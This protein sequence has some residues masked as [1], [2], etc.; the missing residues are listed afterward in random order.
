MKESHKLA[1]IDTGVHRSQS[2][3]RQPLRS[4]EGPI[5]RQYQRA[6]Q[7]DT[8]WVRP[9]IS[10]YSPPSAPY[11]GPTT[12]NTTPILGAMLSRLHHIPDKGGSHRLLHTVLNLLR[13]IRR[14]T[15]DI[16]TNLPGVDTV[17]L[18][19]A[20][21]AISILS[22]TSAMVA[23]TACHRWHRSPLPTRQ[24]RFPTR[25]LQVYRR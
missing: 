8:Q 18:A 16:I 7:F 3:K 5:P 25:L 9:F 22:T 6:S 14:L 12:P 19:V 2:Y 23:P 13:I 21:C 10:D 11:S 1:P 15:A 24:H 17:L 20:R 4:P